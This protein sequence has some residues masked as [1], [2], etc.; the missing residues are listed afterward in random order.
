MAHFRWD[1]MEDGMGELKGEDWLVLV[2][3][4]NDLTFSLSLMTGA[5]GRMQLRAREEL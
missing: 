2:R 4:K 3:S 1:R 5:R